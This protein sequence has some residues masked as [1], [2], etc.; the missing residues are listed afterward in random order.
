MDRCDSSLTLRTDSGRTCMKNRQ[1]QYYRYQSL[2]K[3]LQLDLCAF[4]LKSSVDRRFRFIAPRRSSGLLG[5][6]AAH[7]PRTA[8]MHVD[9]HWSVSMLCLISAISQLL[10]SGV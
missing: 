8:G 6:F 9:R 4:G 7:L 1:A 2:N 10:C 5:R 3:A